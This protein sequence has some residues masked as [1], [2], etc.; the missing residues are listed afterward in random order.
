MTDIALCSNPGHYP[1]CADCARNPENSRAG[2][3]QSWAV[4]SFLDD[5][6]EGYW[7]MEGES[8]G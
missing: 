6:C 2:H 5:E 4:F 3:W 1:D 7:P 8:D